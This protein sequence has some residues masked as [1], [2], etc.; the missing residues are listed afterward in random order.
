[1]VEV[2]SH[3]RSCQLRVPNAIE[4]LTLAWENR[5]EIACNLRSPLPE[6][7]T[8]AVLE[9]AQALATALGLTIETSYT[10]G[11]PG[12]EA[13]LLGKLSVHDVS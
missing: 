13:E 11:P 4:A 5:L 12:G 2:L 7:C 6:H 9:R 8:R 10:T 3:L 1:M